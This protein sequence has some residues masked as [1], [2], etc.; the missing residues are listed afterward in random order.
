MEVLLETEWTR[1]GFEKIYDCLDIVLKVGGGI[2]VDWVYALY[3]L[4]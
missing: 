3:R 2:Q 1:Y 4:L